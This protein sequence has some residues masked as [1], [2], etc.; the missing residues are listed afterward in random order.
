MD[1]LRKDSGRTARY[2]ARDAGDA[3]DKGEICDVC[4]ILILVI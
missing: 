3:C 4:D 1:G 2:E